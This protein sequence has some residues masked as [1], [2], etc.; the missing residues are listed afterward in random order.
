MAPGEYTLSNIP[1][2]TYTVTAS[3]EGYTTQLLTAEVA[4]GMT[5][6]VD[7]QLSKKEYPEEPTTSY[8]PLLLIAAACVIMIVSI[9]MYRK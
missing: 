1:A 4:G 7:F 5:T 6:I 9:A 8:I 2:G 3:K